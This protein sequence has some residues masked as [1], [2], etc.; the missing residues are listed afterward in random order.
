[1]YSVPASVVDPKLFIPF[2]GMNPEPSSYGSG[3]DKSSR[4]HN[5]GTPSYGLLSSTLEGEV[6]S[7]KLKSPKIDM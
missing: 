1:M 2:S 5:T 3:T 4:I 6:G 7:K